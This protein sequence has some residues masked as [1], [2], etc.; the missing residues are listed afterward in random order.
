MS[1]A[2]EQEIPSRTVTKFRTPQETQLTSPAVRALLGLL[3]VVC[4][5]LPC[6]R[7]GALDEVLCFVGKLGKR[8]SEPV[9]GQQGGVCSEVV[10]LQRAL[11]FVETLVFVVQVQRRD[12]DR[13]L[14]VGP[15][16][17]L[18]PVVHAFHGEKIHGRGISR[19]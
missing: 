6:T 19:P 10:F 15:L 16:D 5:L 14:V 7:A 11:G 18:G 4:F 9:D 17:V 3:G 13:Q 2:S 1:T 8:C 12:D